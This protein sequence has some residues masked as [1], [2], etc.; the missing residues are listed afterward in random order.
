M[1]DRLT[2]LVAEMGTQGAPI[3]TRRTG[4]FGAISSDAATPLAMV[5]TELIQNA[6]QHA[7]DEDRGGVIEI[8]CAREGEG[9]LL[10]VEDDGVGLPE[11]FDLEH[12][13][14]LGLSIVSTLMGE[15][16]GT[17]SLGPRDDGT[18]TRVVVQVPERGRSAA[19]SCSG[20]GSGGAYA[21]ACVATLQRTSLVLAESAPDTVVLPGLEGPCEALFAHVAASAHLLGL[22]DLQDRG[23]GVADREEQLR[24][25][26][27]ARGTVTPIH[28]GKPNY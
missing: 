7:F 1:T 21:G 19:L 2:G 5:F 27:E 4:S 17:I 12:A 14:S 3:R 22:L 16:G 20:S 26:V 9:L 11:G 8:H 15:L 23:P 25:L 13:E 18:G 24:V 6:V 28:W 10:S